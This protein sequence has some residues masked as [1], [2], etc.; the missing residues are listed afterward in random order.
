MQK[1]DSKRD[2]RLQAGASE[3]KGQESTEL[4]GCPGEGGEGRAG[5]GG[6]SV[7]NSW[8][9]EEEMCEGSIWGFN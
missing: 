3:R 6:R 9:S 7:L 4:S 5:E 2:C 8:Y 1:T